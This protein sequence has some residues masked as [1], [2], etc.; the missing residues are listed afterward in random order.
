[1]QFGL[2]YDFRNPPRWER[3][4]AQLYGQLLDQIAYAEELGYDYIWLSEHHFS[5]DGYLP[6]LLTMAA[7]IAARTKRVKIGTAVLL[8]PLQNAL[9]LAED[10]AVVD[11]ISNGRLVLGL[12]LGWTPIEFEA[13][14]VPIKQR[15]SRT[16]EAVEVIKRAW[17]EDRFT[18]HGKYHHLENITVMPK[19]AQQPRPPILIGG[20]GEGAT[21]RAARIGDGFIGGGGGS[22][23]KLTEQFRAA[24]AEQGRDRK[25]VMISTTLPLYVTDDPERD[26][27]RIRDFVQ[28]QANW[29]LQGSGRTIDDPD[30]LRKGFVIA[31]PDEAV[32]QVKKRQADTDCDELHFWAVLPGQDPADA[33]RSIELFAKQVMPKVR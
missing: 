28:Y 33:Q 27:P 14:D 11:L 12:G 18:F 10:A 29:Y 4:W 17:T 1:M 24:L 26:W 9:R 3:P 20:G 16:E 13:L 2:W 7:A 25:D 15:V 8:T 30:S 21:S 31:A 6:S 22:G 19:P 32:E 5:D 23:Q